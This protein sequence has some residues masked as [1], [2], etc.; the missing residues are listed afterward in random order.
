MIFEVINKSYDIEKC[1]SNLLKTIKKHDKEGGV[2]AVHLACYY[3]K[4]EML[5]ILHK[6][7]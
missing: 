4:L 3:G 6:E 1:K 2:E 7:Y 5:S